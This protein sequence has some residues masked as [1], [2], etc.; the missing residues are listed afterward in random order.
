MQYSVDQA[1]QKK[2]LRKLLGAR[3]AALSPAE[4]ECKAH[5]I[6][7][8]IIQMP[9]FIRSRNILLYA[10]LPDEVRTDEFLLKLWHEK[11]KRVILPKVNETS[12]QIELY[13]VETASEL[14][15]GVFGVREPIPEVCTQIAPREVDCVLVPGRGFD[16]RGHRLGRGK[17][18]YDKL[19]SLMRPETELIGVFF[20]CQKADL[21]PDEPHDW[22]LHFA[23][24]EKTVYE[25]PR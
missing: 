12:G 24:T 22:K 11:G 20:E 3:V 1:I 23:V 17:G 19:L 9:G 7:R 13:A 8:T 5:H 4:M 25:F 15:H 10:S 21:L 2:E 6:C 18:Y 14:M 16:G